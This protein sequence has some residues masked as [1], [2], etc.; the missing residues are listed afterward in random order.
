MPYSVENIV[1]KGE[2]ACY[3]QFLLFSQC[4]PRLNVFSASKCGIV[5]NSLLNNKIK[6]ERLYRQLKRSRNDDICPERMENIVGR[7]VKSWLPAFPHVSTMLFTGFC[8][9]VSGNGFFTDRQTSTPIIVNNACTDDKL[10]TVNT[11]PVLDGVENMGQGMG[12]MLV[13]SILPFPTMFL[14]FTDE[15][16]TT[17]AATIILSSAGAF[18][19]DI[20]TISSS[21]KEIRVT[22]VIFLFINHSRLP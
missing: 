3:N 7:G 14:Y 12:K 18:T 19:L 6:I 13:I 1:R 20:C 4:F 22:T 9:K 10:N 11:K 5:V 17:S 21:G 8:R 2:T 16:S 15:I